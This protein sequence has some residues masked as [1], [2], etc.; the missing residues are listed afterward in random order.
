MQRIERTIWRLGVLMASASLLA[1]QSARAAEPASDPVQEIIV[2]GTQS[3]GETMATASAPIAVYDAAQLEASGYPDVG[4]ALEAIAPSIN[5]PHSATSPSASSTRSVTMKGL[6]PDQVLVLIDGKRW[7][8]SAVLVSNNTIGRGS[9]PYDLA[10]IPLSAVERIEVLDDSAAAQY[11]SDAIAGVVNII[12]K[13]NA[14]GGVASAQGGV[15]DAGDG[16]N[17]DVGASQGFSFGNGGRLTISGDLRHQDPTNRAPID[18]RTGNVDQ[19]DGE[20]QLLDAGVAVNAAYPILPHWSLYGTLIT[21]FRQ[22]STVA[23]F[24]LPGS[25]MLY[26][27]GF[28]PRIDPT[29]WNLTAIGGAKGDWAGM[30]VDLSNSFGLSNAQFDIANSANDSLGAAS[31]TQFDDGAERYM[32]DTVNLSLSHPL[33]SNL[34]AG[35]ISGGGEFR[36]ENYKITPGEPGSYEQGGAQN[37]PGFDPRVPV[38]NSRTAE[39][40]FVDLALRPLARLKFDLAGRYDH[41]SDFGGAP[42][43]KASGRW[44]TTDWL[45][46]RGSLGTGFRAPSLQQRFFSTTT[47]QFT[48]NLTLTNTG[49]YQVND[50][51]ARALGATPLKPEDSTNYS[52]GIV[53]RPAPR[54]LIT[55]DGFLV[56]IRNRIILSNPLTGP[57]VT[58]ILAAQ[59]VTNVQQVAFFT[60][61]AHTSTIGYDLGVSYSLPLT[62]ID[63][64]AADIKYGA[65]HTSL[66]SLAPNSV[67]PS[68]PLLGTTSEALLLSAQPSDK[69]TSTLT[70]THDRVSAILGVDRYGPWMAAPTGALQT[71][72]GKTL[73]DLGARVAISSRMTI[74]AGVQNIG[75]VYPD[76]AKGAGAIGTKYGDETPFGLDGRSYFLRL[77]VSN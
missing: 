5:V 60:N 51:I 16:W 43:W 8:T 34:M 28:L 36:F 9:A 59:G 21:D 68:L 4:R 22:T 18:P 25:S 39:G 27:N 63:S 3:A 56:D 58:S 11:G 72:T 48:S 74:S 65:Y 67:V 10:A 30:K 53:L 15:T 32:Q 57:A 6:A 71:F 1:I 55:A 64:L 40:A 77:Q 29:I 13:K 46:F 12:L 70:Y 23:V 41:Y 31:P 33:P 2:T 66:V 24:V 20:P 17:Y 44:D 50:P 49:T 26:P 37:F 19:R 54:L 69:L 38:D 61:A 42:T 14:S 52:A 62:K 73:V 45:A 76:V 7:Q 35:D 47:T 75:N